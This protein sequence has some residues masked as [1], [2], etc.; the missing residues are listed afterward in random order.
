MFVW[1]EGT[2]EER[3]RKEGN[4]IEKKIHSRLMMNKM[5]SKI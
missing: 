3:N 4:E 5:E 1:D 2:V